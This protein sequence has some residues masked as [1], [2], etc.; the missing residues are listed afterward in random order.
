MRAR[1]E[2]LDDRD[3]ATDA[4]MRELFAARLNRRAKERGARGLRRGALEDVRA[5]YARK[6]NLLDGLCPCGTPLPCPGCGVPLLE[7]DGKGG[8]REKIPGIPPV[9]KQARRGAKRKD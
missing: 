9:S 1:G 8:L 4:R 6:Q 7:I 2:V 5:R 3:A